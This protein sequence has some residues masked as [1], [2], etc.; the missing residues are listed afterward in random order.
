M[1]QRSG[2]TSQ[3]FLISSRHDRDGMRRGL[4]FE[5]VRLI[6]AMSKFTVTLEPREFE[7]WLPWAD[8]LKPKD[9]PKENTD[10]KDTR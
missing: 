9:K 6:D 10:G 4:G 7:D 1:G 5:A 3:T 2:S 8:P